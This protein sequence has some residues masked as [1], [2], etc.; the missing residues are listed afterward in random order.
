MCCSYFLYNLDIDA[1]RVLQNLC[2]IQPRQACNWTK[3]VST[4]DLWV[5]WKYKSSPNDNRIRWWFVL[6]G[7]ETTWKCWRKPGWQQIAIRIEWSL[8][9]VSVMMLIQLSHPLHP[10]HQS[11]TLRV[12]DMPLWSQIVRVSIYNRGPRRSSIRPW[13]TY[14]VG[15]KLKVGPF[16]EQ[17]LKLHY[18]QQYC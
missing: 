3:G 5:K 4:N 18:L 8:S 9:F 11:L 17:R 7:E 2:N 14:H 15:W 1:Y 12:M 10:Q 16:C 13:T 6:R